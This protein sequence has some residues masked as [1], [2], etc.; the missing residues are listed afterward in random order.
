MRAGQDANVNLRFSLSEIL[1]YAS[2][3][4]SFYSNK[5]IDL[6]SY[7]ASNAKLELILLS[8]LSCILVITA[9]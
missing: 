5:L 3:M 9:Q 8:L 6:R 1:E 7:R 4:M 2:F